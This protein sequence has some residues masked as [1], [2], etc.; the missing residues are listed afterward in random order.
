MRSNLLYLLTF[1]FVTPLAA[2]TL[3]SSSATELS[4]AAATT[5][6]R[7]QAENRSRL[8][9]DIPSPRG[10]HYVYLDD[11]NLGS[12]EG[13]APE[14]QVQPG[15]RSVTTVINAFTPNRLRLAGDEA[16]IGTVRLLEADA[17][18]REIHLKTRVNLQHPLRVRVRVRERTRSNSE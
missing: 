17:A 7:L 3:S 6:E 15:T 13:I 12:G 5:F 8:F 18:S 1:A 4:A 14:I 2:Q 10:E 9:S 16:S 11:S